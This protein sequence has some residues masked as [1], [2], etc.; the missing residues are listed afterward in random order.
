MSDLYMEQVAVKKALENWE[1][2]KMEGLVLV[3]DGKPLA[4]TM[5]S[6]LCESAFD[7]HFEKA[8]ASVDGAYAAINRG[9]ARYLR[10]KYP[11]VE[12]LNREDDLGLEGLRKAKLSYNPARLIE[13]SWAVLR[14]DG[15]EY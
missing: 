5:G 13:K 4:V 1:T 8:L 7:V 3:E 12:Y 14:E 2:L 15:Y 11:E 6:R 10:E 9:F